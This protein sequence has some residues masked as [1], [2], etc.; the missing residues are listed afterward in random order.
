MLKIKLSVFV[1]Q[2][3]FLRVGL[4][5]KADIIYFV[6]INLRAIEYFYI[7]IALWWPNL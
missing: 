4:T 2:R 6:I 1:C 3:V 7:F 5:A